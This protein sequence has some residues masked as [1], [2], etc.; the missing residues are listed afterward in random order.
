MIKRAWFLISIV[1]SLLWSLVLIDA[2]RRA[3][4][5]PA[6]P[7]GY[8]LDIQWGPIVLSIVLLCAPWLMFPAAKFIAGGR[9]PASH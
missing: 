4:D 1:W 7:A 9:K 5:V 3:F 6:I 2:L 8:S